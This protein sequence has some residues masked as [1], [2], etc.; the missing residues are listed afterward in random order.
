ME[1]SMLQGWLL[2]GVGMKLLGWG[3]IWGVKAGGSLVP[4]QVLLLA[5][6]CTWGALWDGCR[7]KHCRKTK[8]NKI[9]EV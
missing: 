5:G 7:Q 6:P 4:P 9:K 8:Q 1:R 3:E 2:S